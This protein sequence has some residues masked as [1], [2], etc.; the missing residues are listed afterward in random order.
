MDP[1][2]WQAFEKIVAAMHRAETHGATVRWNDSINGR[3]FDVTVKFQRG[4]FSFLTVLDC[5]ASTNPVTVKK[6]EGFV[7]KAPEV[8]ANKGVVVSTVGFQ[9]G[10]YPVAERY[11]IS[12]LTV[13]DALKSSADPT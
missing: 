8:S 7:T 9:R 6:V 4:L 1:R 13:T 10:C 5:D 11:G 12:L 2:E 3:K